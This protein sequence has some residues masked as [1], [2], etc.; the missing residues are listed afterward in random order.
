MKKLKLM[1]L[2]FRLFLLRATAHKHMAQWLQLFVDGGGEN[3]PV[4]GALYG[5]TKFK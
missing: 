3:I 1:W 5:S 2:K 4:T